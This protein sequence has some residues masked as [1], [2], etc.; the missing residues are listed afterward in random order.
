VTH[1]GVASL[2]ATQIER[3]G[4]GP[5]SRVLQFASPSFDAAFWELVMGLLTGAALVVAPAQDL[6]PGEPLAATV[7]GHGVTHATIPPVAL[8]VM[9]SDDLPTVTTL[10]VA[11]EA[12]SGELVERWSAGRRMVNAYGPTESTVCATMSGALEGGGLPPI[13]TPVTNTQVLVLDGGLRPV[14][15]GVAGELYIAGAGLARGYLGRPGLTSE[16]FVANPY[17]GP[18]ERMYRSGDVVRWTADGE[19]EFLG[20]ADDQ[21]KV[22][23][24][25]IELG[26]IESV[27][28]RHPAIGQVAVVVRE[29][30]PGDKQIVAYPVPE[31]GQELPRPAALRAHV[32]AD[33]PDYM[34]PA[35]FV[36]I[37]AIPVTPNGKLDRKALPL[38]DLAALAAGRAPRTP[39]EEILCGLFAEILGLPRVGIDDS[40]FDLGGHSLQATRLVSRIRSVFDAELPL[41]SLFETAT[42]AGLALLLRD[43]DSARGAVRAVERPDRVPLSF[44]QR[45]LWF[46]AG[47]DGPS[48]GY[49][50]PLALRLTGA[51]DRH[52]LGAA[53]GDVVARHESLRTVFAEQD[54]R[55]HQVILD[56]G[57]A[58]PVL[59]V[60]PA[61]GADLDEQLAAA[62]AHGF[63]L[64]G[65]IPL[66]ATLFTLGDDEYVLLLL[67]HH[68]AG[69]GWSLAPLAR[70]LSVA[71]AARLD[72][73]APGWEP[74]PVQY[75]DYT[76]WQRELLGDEGED[77]S[78]GA[79]Q[80]DHWRRSL[81]G[82]PEEL[83][84]PTDRPRPARASYQGD[85]VPFAVPPKLHAK[86]AQL[87]RDS[88]TSLFMVLQAG[89]AALLNR[90]GAG[91]DI[92]L[93]TAVAGRTDESLDQLVGFFVNNLVL[94]TDTGGDPTFRELLARVRET[95]LAA[96]ANQDTSFERLVEVLNPGRSLARHPLFQVMLTLQNNERGE[97]ALP[98]LR[99]GP[100][101]VQTHS[102]RFDLALEMGEKRGGDGTYDG[103]EGVVE[104]STDLFDRSTV[105]KLTKRYLRLLESVAADA[106]RTIG[107][108][109]VLGPVERHELVMRNNA[110]DHEVAPATLHA[111]VEEQARR[112]PDARALLFEGRGLTYRQLD[113]QADRLAH[114]LVQEGVGP[115]RTVAV[116]VPRSVELVVALLAVLKAGGAYLPVDPDYPA[117]RIGY[118]LEHAAPALLLTTAGVDVPG[119][120]DLP[121]LV[122]DDP[123]LIGELAAQ[124]A[125]RPDVTVSPAAP[126]YVIYT[127]GS[128]GRPKGVVVPHRGIVNRLQWMQHEYGLTADD[129]VMQKTPSGFDVSVW[130][131]FWPLITGA[132]LVVARPEGHRDPA[133]LARLIRETGITTLHF[134][135]S[136]LQAFLAD[137]AAADCGD[138]L[139]RVLCSGEALPLDVQTRF[140]E[141]LDAELHNLYGPTEASVD[142]TAWA[143]EPDS[144]RRTVP[145]GRP[146]WNTRVY[147]LDEMLRPVAHGVQGELYLAGDQLARGYLG[148][149]DLTADRF[150]AAPF[151]EPGAR[152]YRTGDLVRWAS[153]NTLEY[154]GRA[155][156]QVKMR[157]LRIEL[158]EIEAVLAAQDGVTQAVVLLREDQPGDQRLVAYVVVDGDTA[159]DRDGLRTRAAAVLP[160]YMVPTAFVI[161]DEL[162]LS[163]NGKLDRKALP[164][165]DYAEA[166]AV[167]EPRTPQEAT[168]CALFAE[169]LGVPAVGPDDNF[170]ALGG[171]SLLGT[172]LISRI[173]TEFGV[174]MPVR[175]IFEA[176]T[177]AGIATLLHDAADARPPLVPMPRPEQL[178]VS[179][180][181]QRLWFLGRLDGDSAAY[182]LPLAL[183]ISGGLDTAALRAALGDVVAR[184]ESLRTVFQ[185]IAGSPV[186]VVLDA[187]DT[188]PAMP[189]AETTE[190]ALPAALARAAG[191]GF[192]LA[193]DIPLNAT[194]FRTGA[195][196]HVLLLV[197]HHIA[198]DGASLAPLAR[199]L[200]Q[201]YAARCEGGAP[202]WAP[203]P[204]QYADYALWQRELL[205][206]EADP[207]SVVSQQLSFWQRAL[208]GVPEELRLPADRPRPARPTYRG[209]TVPLEFD[210]QVHSGL[211]ALAEESGASLFMVL[212]AGLASFLSAVGAGTDVPL[213]TPVAGRG[214]EALDELVGFFVN[215]LVLRTDVSG[216]P[217]FREVLARVRETDLAAYAH[218]DVPFERLVDLISPERS[219]ARHPLFQVMLTLQNNAAARMDLGGLDVRAEDTELGAAKFD[220]AVS[221][222]ERRDEE[223]RPAGLGGFVDYSV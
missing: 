135:P 182:N 217:T 117:D 71:Y 202:E 108:I 20:R 145:I 40:F 52:A 86:L 116:A 176:P 222:G 109:D 73:A 143:C 45:R 1:S 28:A 136:M 51:L 139:R 106:D 196:E 104:Y 195:T 58:T 91:T 146:V 81:A 150:V 220:L 111:L 11:G 23:G 185:E 161:L 207:T 170:F 18:G 98:G 37:D 97:L 64:A 27:L 61:T 159:S 166:A 164:A 4:V 74:L 193:R 204:V 7:T 132:T 205:G 223:G 148:R 17:G 123:A 133:Y 144:G 165:P 198:A 130:E 24:F 83:T 149:P 115:E 188:R 100:H 212:Q 79:A 121:R 129:R 67:L 173:R 36:A 55:P 211:A 172:R 192:D 187:D 160:E 63:D 154:L 10:V 184:H 190:D 84:L 82:L 183:R 128:T 175:V 6:A 155:D 80:L 53:L 47:F 113:E 72:G 125:R 46:L 179:Y 134:V 59:D 16:R 44:A 95:D 60:R 21:V 2:V 68:I 162:P 15:A 157:G 57:A 194:L 101:S 65:E 186:Q 137:P 22:R 206:D 103:I 89:L 14:P 13:G 94:R 30:R 168:L 34:V 177:P 152:M 19:L 49:N 41:R 142:V 147:V 75:A 163:P 78:E 221:F 42:P 35:A 66:R 191:T 12:T 201:A 153:D 96:Y 102:S 171:H 5:G 38:P 69:D 8:A 167:R 50:I 210:P 48:A 122:L 197:V 151:G 120:K 92:P 31:P 180:A 62:A 39:Q 54:G 216:D 209:D 169:V 93:G 158:G 107:R 127:S 219:L 56:A 131:F 181:Q 199:D 25:R 88:N 140:F 3:F 118:I 126:A 114:R 105:E 203:L 99:V 214:D 208:A 33:L 70:D 213:G 138:S 119:S 29:D 43:T 174:E 124:G 218:Q 200:S 9:A 189:I 87:S 77:S 178:P 85:I 32:G 156:H 76:L 141:V 110:T 26:E 90:L 112:T 215:T